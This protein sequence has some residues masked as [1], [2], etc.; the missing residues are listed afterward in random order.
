MGSNRTPDLGWARLAPW[1]LVALAVCAATGTARGA[2]CVS[3]RGGSRIALDERANGFERLADS[4]AL[5]GMVHPDQPAPPANTPPCRGSICS[6]NPDSP[7]PSPP[8]APPEREHWA[9]L[10]PTGG[11]PPSDATPAPTDDASAHPSHD[12]LGVF[13][14]PRGA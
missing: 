5:A 6:K 13:H 14:P 3:H 11:P 7:A 8:P 10:T 2:G 9:Y 12:R 4:G 1:A